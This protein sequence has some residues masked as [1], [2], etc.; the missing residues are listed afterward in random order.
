MKSRIYHLIQ[1]LEHVM[2][3]TPW[4]GDSV[5]EKLEQMDIRLVNEV[6]A[7]LT[8][9]IARLVKHMISWRLFAIEKL[10]GNAAYDIRIN[11]HEDW[12]EITI[13]TNEQW[14]HLLKELHDTQDQL[15]TQLRARNEEDLEQPCLGKSYSL[16]FLV[17]G[18]LQ[19]DVYH[20]GQ[21]ALIEK[22]LVSDPRS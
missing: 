13:Q 18:I 4:Y 3:G 5:M 20:L 7:G 10:N 15:F 6:P 12:P 11:T 21:I 17:E 1:S 16:G 22:I 8:N 19:H 9:S 14:R 2:Q